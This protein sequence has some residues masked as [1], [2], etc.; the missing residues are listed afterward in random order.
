MGKD[1]SDIYGLDF[2]PLKP[3]AISKGFLRLPAAS[4]VVTKP[5]CVLDLDLQTIDRL[6]PILENIPYTV[7]A[8]RKDTV[9]ALLA[10]FDYDF[11]LGK[12]LVHVS[13]SPFHPPTHW[14]QTVFYLEEPLHVRQ[15][16]SISGTISFEQSMT[17][18]DL[19]VR[20]SYALGNDNVSD[21]KVD[22]LWQA[23]T[24]GVTGD[25]TGP[26]N[27]TITSRGGSGVYKV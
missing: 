6:D 2:S 3:A 20:L 13:T 11:T 26:T 5:T 9:H 17:Q 15:G 16:D 1:W 21:G 8:N 25:G 4:Q 24:N 22:L 19:S 7:V 27:G 18:R 23:D 12:G 10:W 14:K